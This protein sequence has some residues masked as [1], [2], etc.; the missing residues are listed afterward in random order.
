[1]SHWRLLPE[2]AVKPRPEPKP[3]EP[4]PAI[5]P[6]QPI[7]AAMVNEAHRAATRAMNAIS[8]RM[9]RDAFGI[10]VDEFGNVVPPDTPGGIGTADRINQAIHTTG[11]PIAQAPSVPTSFRIA[12]TQG[13]GITADLTKFESGLRAAGKPIPGPAENNPDS[14]PET[15]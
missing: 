13:D 14:G 12:R 6:G 10:T 7:A 5:G 9:H 8:E 11:L 1:V 15:I 4:L 2:P 3:A